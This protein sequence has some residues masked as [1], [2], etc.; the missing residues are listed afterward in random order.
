M[1]R[2]I[3]FLS[4]LLLV[5]AGGYAAT[6]FV[7][8]WQI[9]EAVRAGDVKTLEQK[10]DWA[11]VRQSLKQSSGATRAALAEYSDVANAAGTKPGLWQR[12]KNAA[13]PMFA[14]PLIDRYVTAEGAP[15]IYAWRQS[16]REKV[17]PTLGLAEP[18]SV[19]DGTPMA[20]TGLDRVLSVARRLDRA[21]FVSPTRIEAELRDRYRED[22]RWKAVLELQDWSWRLTEVHV[23]NGPRP[24]AAARLVNN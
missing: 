5:L 14:D 16:W 4:A 3:V 6:P 13:A 19:L 9:R 11:A 8:L 22:R 7:T 18:K 2:R 23:L 1:V 21:A 17:R 10:V 20:G 24:A 15:Q 12:I